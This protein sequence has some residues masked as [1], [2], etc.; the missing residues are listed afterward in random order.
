[1]ITLPDY[2][3]G[4]NLNHVFLTQAEYNA[5]SDD[6]KNDED[7]LYMIT[8]AQIDVY[9]TESQLNEAIRTIELT[10][11]PQGD[12]GEQ[13]IQGP[14]GD[15]GDTGEQ[16][17]QG[18]KGDKGDKLTYADL[19]ET[20]KADLTRGFITCSSVVNRI[21]VVDSLPAYEVPGVIYFVKE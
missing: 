5:L 12:Q 6:E 17:E 10:P 16:G 15:K 7:T 13:G 21:E 11:G 9:V 8:D 3:E 20:D 18:P 4:D 2:P 19:T 14:K 1:V